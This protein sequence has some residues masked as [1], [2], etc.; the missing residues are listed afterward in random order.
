MDNEIRINDISVSRNHAVLNFIDN[1]VF[2]NDY[3]SKF[4][5]LILL[6]KPMN[7]KLSARVLPLQIGRTVFKIRSSWDSQAAEAF[8]CKSM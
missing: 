4:G 2:F 3:N 5:S 8:C 1:K 6:R 7:L